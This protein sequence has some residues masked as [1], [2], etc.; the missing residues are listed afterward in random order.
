[1]TRVKGAGTSTL[2]N[3]YALSVTIMYC[4]SH[5]YKQNDILRRMLIY[6]FPS[7]DR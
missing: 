4:F 6:V 1:M 7:D 5:E 2:V 3:I